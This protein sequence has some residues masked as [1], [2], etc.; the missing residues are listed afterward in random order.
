MIGLCCNTCTV[1]AGSEQLCNILML[2][3]DEAHSTA[4]ETMD[5]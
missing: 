1:A 5:L 4:E 2:C 3:L